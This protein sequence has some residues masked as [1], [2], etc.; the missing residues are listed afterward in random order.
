MQKS[1]SSKSM[2][3]PCATPIPS[4]RWLTLALLWLLGS[5]SIAVGADY[6]ISTQADFDTYRQA[7]FAPGDNILFE[8]GK[9]FNGMF[10]P[11]AVGT[12]NN[13]VTIS[14]YGDGA[15]PVIHNNGVIHPHPTRSGATVSAGV[16]LFNSEYVEVRN[17]EI[18]NNN[19]GNQSEDLFG[20]YV[21]GED[22]GKYHNHI[23]IEDNYV[24]HVNG[25]VA[26]KRR[27]GIHVHGYSPTSSNTATYNDVRIVNNVV[28]QIGGV[29]IGT[30]IDDLVNAHDFVGTHRENAITNLYVAHNWI[31]NTGRN[32]V[33][34]RDSD[35]AV[36][37]YNTSANSSRHSTGHS[38]FNFRTIG[39]TFQYNEAY[40]NTGPENEPDR[41][42]F[43][44]D[45][46]SKGT[47]IQ[48]NYSHSNNWSAGIMKRP[49]TDV[50]IRYNLS[51]NDEKG[52]YFYGF[53]N[54]TDLTDL[55]IYN[56]THYYDATI[57]PEI[58]VRDRTPIEST[59]NNNI[60][61]AAG[62]GT[63][64][65]NANNG[66]NVTYDTN[67]YHNISPPASETNGLTQN[68]L[69]VSPGAEPHDIDMEFGRDVLS[70]YMLSADSPYRDTGVSIQDNGSLDFWG[71]WVPHGATDLG[72]NEFTVGGFTGPP[73][74][75]VTGDLFPQAN[76]ANV[77]AA[78]PDT[79]SRFGDDAHASLTQTFQV[80]SAF[81]LKSI[82]LNYEYDAAVDPNDILINL[83]IFEVENVAANLFVPGKSLLTLNGLSMPDLNSAEEA[84]IVLDSA[85]SLSATSGAGGYAL[86]I[87]NGGN[88][89]FEWRRTGSSAGSV[90]AYGQAYE[91]GV[92]KFEGERDFVLALSEL[93]IGLPADADFDNDDDVDGTGFLIWQQGLGTIGAQNSDGDADHDNDVDG[94]DLLVWN[95][96]YG[97]LAP[98]AR[99]AAVP[100][101]SSLISCLLGS[102]LLYFIAGRAPNTTAD[103]YGP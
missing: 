31:G 101:P 49:N 56:N 81:D 21:L 74:T 19:G 87:T 2:P 30:D 60:F 5:R 78:M 51:V 88:P 26:G 94:D 57:S 24:H 68:P 90:Y 37:E 84:A 36:Y 42:G 83:E 14:A 35:Y 52:A 96:Q 95:T 103:R 86:Q 65:T 48:Y 92:E 16:L 39:L 41:G 100:E 34:A 64:G 97:S 85:V 53:E 66:T 7:T 15:K 17:L 80:D 99:A 8:R 40:G 93:A 75:V 54:D 89:G 58:I 69:F 102:S 82:V 20:I 22:T 46:N 9:V 38:F 43:D 44:A 4:R 67:V 1:Y 6:F 12:A 18:T 32:T 91:D 33:I 71:N 13:V 50:T 77:V 45:Y 73:V 70:G 47:V 79:V 11:T 59:F 28:D 62:S 61:Y 98:L 3:H 27:G 76:R 23:Y 10:A 72:A 63:M 25:A 55:K 29:G